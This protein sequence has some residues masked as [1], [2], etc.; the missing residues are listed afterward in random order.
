MRKK[1]I[2]SQSLAIWR[3]P[4]ALFF[5]NIHAALRKKC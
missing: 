4:E 5:R 3:D 1:S 2:G